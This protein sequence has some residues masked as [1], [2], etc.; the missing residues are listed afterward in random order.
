MRVKSSETLLCC[1]RCW[2][3]LNRN[4]SW[5]VRIF[6]SQERRKA[7]SNA[8]RLKF[9]LILLNWLRKESRKPWGCEVYDAWRTL[10]AARLRLNW[11][12]WH[13]RVRLK[14]HS[15]FLTATLWKVTQSRDSERTWHSTEE[16]SIDI[17]MWCNIVVMRVSRPTASCF[18]AIRNDSASQVYSDSN[19]EFSFE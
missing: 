4:L 8:L 18:V 14:C 1:R 3:Y 6:F 17:I 10:L 9:D 2:C 5:V 19:N 7:F 15:C 16:P 12:D 11:S 13:H